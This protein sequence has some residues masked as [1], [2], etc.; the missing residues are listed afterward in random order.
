MHFVANDSL[1]I[2]WKF[3]IDDWKSVATVASQALYNVESLDLIWWPDLRWPGDK[4][5][6]KGAE[7]MASK[8]GKKRIL[9]NRGGLPP[10]LHVGRD[11]S[12]KCKETW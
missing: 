10:I 3:H 1:I 11:L 2:S 5:F 9:E 8:E 4:N 7:M 6:R 12:S